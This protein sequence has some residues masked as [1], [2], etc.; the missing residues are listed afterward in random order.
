MSL[1]IFL[2]KALSNSVSVTFVTVVGHGCGFDFTKTLDFPRALGM[3]NST[4]RP[5][6]SSSKAMVALVYSASAMAL[7]ALFPCL[8]ALNEPTGPWAMR[9]WSFVGLST[10]VVI[11][12]S[13][14]LVR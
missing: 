3:L 4:I 1:W 8:K 2:E 7:F 9:I 14:Y 11:G 10:S 5:N 13:G 6:P 12:Q